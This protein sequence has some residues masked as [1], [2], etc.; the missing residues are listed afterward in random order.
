MH[1]DRRA[2]RV[3]GLAFRNCGP[4]S[5]VHGS[6]SGDNRYSA[7]ARFTLRFSAYVYFTTQNR[8]SIAPEG[9]V[10]ADVSA[11]GGL[12]MKEFSQDAQWH[13]GSS[14][15]PLRTRQRQTGYQATISKAF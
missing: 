1:R 9:R 4:R 6:R 3:V 12:T 8:D 10:S 15:A 13:E 11:N 14:C 5:K 7:C 2:G